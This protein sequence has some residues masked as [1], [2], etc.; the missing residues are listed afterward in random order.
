MEKLMRIEKYIRLIDKYPYIFSNDYGALTIVTDTVELYKGQEEL[1][2]IADAKNHPR[3]WYDIGVIAEDNWVVVL[4]DLVS[5]PNGKYCGYIRSLNRRSQVERSGKDVVILV[6]VDDR[7]LLINHFRHDDRTWHWECPR[8]FGEAGL[9]PLENAIKEVTE[10]TGIQVNQIC[11]LND[12]TDRVSYFIAECSG[13]IFNSDENELISD[14]KLVSKSEFESMIASCRINDM[15]T[16]R[17][18]VLA[19]L[20]GLV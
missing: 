20:K 18:F 3:E 15:Y 11:Q 5:L 14:I 6:K 8:G 10:E 12:E 16:L 4:R 9:S 19:C 2:R 13:D 7:F 1:Y 17:A